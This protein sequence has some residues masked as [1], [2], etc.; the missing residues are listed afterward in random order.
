MNVQKRDRIVYISTALDASGH[1]RDADL[2]LELLQESEN[3]MT[4]LLFMVALN[5]ALIAAKLWGA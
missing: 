2:V 3:R 5:V 1:R 4:A